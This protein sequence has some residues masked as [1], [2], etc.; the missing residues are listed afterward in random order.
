M[1]GGGNIRR[2]YNYHRSSFIIISYVIVV[3]NH[4]NNRLVNMIS[5]PLYNITAISIIIMIVLATFLI[6]LLIII[7]LRGIAF[8]AIIVKGIVI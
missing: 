8:L 5:Y 1:R 3:T 7:S 2:T 6:P 4:I